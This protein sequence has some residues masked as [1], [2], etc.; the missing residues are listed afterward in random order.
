MTQLLLTDGVRQEFQGP[1]ERLAAEGLSD[2]RIAAQLGRS[3][4]RHQIYHLRKVFGIRPGADSR[5]P[6]GPRRAE[7]PGRSNETVAIIRVLLSVVDDLVHLDARTFEYCNHRYGARPCSTTVYRLED[8][9]FVELHH[10]G[11]V[12]ITDAGKQ[13][14]DARPDDVCA[15]TGQAAA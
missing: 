2:A 1:V 13:W 14:L 8:R 4:T 11:S 3:L 10:D 12:T 15:I 9:G 6:A 5:V 7:L